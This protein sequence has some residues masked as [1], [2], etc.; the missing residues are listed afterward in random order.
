MKTHTLG[1]GQLVEFIVPVKGMKHMNIKQIKPEKM[2]SGLQ[3][4]SKIEQ[5]YSSPNGYIGG[6]LAF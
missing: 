6:S 1:A 4:D 2:F 5:S 3:R